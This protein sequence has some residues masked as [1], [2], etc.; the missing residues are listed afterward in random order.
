VDFPVRL[1]F[2]GYGYRLQLHSLA[3]C[4]AQGSRRL[5]D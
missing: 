1:N 5:R 3:Q 2:R 4:I